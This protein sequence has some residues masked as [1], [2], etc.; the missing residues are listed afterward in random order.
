MAL[1]GLGLGVAASQAGHLLAY[2][3]RYGAG[4]QQ[5]QSSGAHAYFPTLVKTGLGAAAAV[6]LIGL[7]LVGFARVAAGRPLPH[8]P[9]PS[10]LRLIA[11]LFTVQLTCFLLQEAAEAAVVGAPPS[12][13]AVLLLWGTTGQ[14]PVALIAALALRWLLIR[15]GPAIAELRLFLW[16]AY[17]R[18]VYA[19]TVPALSPADDLVHSGEDLNRGFNRRGPPS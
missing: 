13:P 9:A 19:V 15:L 16:P 7:V 11:V 1:L 3:V 6:T 14:L 18:F 17:Q 12:S 5:L 10:L 8:Q 2:A 4:A